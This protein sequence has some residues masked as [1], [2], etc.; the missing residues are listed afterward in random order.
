MDWTNRHLVAQ[1]FAFPGVGAM[2]NTPLPLKM[3]AIEAP[4]IP[5]EIDTG[6]RGFWFLV[7]SQFVSNWEP[8]AK[9]IRQC[10]SWIREGL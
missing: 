6:L 3:A 2:E 7:I 9:M 4:E 5:A 8:I 10:I 1:T